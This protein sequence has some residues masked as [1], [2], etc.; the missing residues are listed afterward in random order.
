MEILI[1]NL[2]INQIQKVAGEHINLM[3]NDE[4][5]YSL[6]GKLGIYPAEKCLSII[7]KKGTPYYLLDNLAVLDKPLILSYQDTVYT[8]NQVE[9]LYLTPRMN[10]LEAHHWLMNNLFKGRGNQ[11]GRV[12]ARLK[13]LYKV[14]KN[15][16]ERPDWKL[17]QLEWMKAVLSIKYKQCEDFRNLLH[18][19]GNFILIEDAT[20][21]NYDSNCFWGAKKVI[22]DEA[23]YFVGANN[24]GKTLMKLRANNGCLEY[25][26]PNDLHLFG[27]PF[28]HFEY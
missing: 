27:T 9:Q 16:I 23:E 26:I 12:D 22:I 28:K 18:S 14:K 19:T 21:T 5:E 15:H 4:S 20:E 25:Q 1:K 3:P 7:T 24:M 11:K 13:R 17:I 8:F 6:I 10:N 2:N